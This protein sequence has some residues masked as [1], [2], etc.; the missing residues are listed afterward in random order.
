MWVGDM[1]RKVSILKPRGES[2]CVVCSVVSVQYPEEDQLCCVRTC[3][4]GW[5]SSTEHYIFYRLYAEEQLW[6][7][8]EWE[9]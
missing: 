8:Q 5:D 3:H 1:D 2:A 9:G 4:S 7:L 6:L